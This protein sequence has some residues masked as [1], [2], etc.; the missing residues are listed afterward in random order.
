MFVS[1][2]NHPSRSLIGVRVALTI[3]VLQAA[4]WYGDHPGRVTAQ[5]T[6]GKVT[7]VSAASFESNG[8]V[9]PDSIVAAFGADLA[10]ITQVANTFPLP[11]IISNVTVEVNGRSAALLF[12][13]PG[14][15]NSCCPRIWL[16]EPGSY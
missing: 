2:D 1:Q 6:V 4:L 14:Q 3:L 11:T 8:F 7:S 9:T 12:I 5:Q 16:K 10:T 15:I 13:S